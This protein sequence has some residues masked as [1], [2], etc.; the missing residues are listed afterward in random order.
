MGGLR[1]L[2]GQLRAGRL[3]GSGIRR[4]RAGALVGPAPAPH[5]RD[6]P[7]PASA[8]QAAEVTSILNGSVLA[9]RRGSARPV[10]WPGT[11][12]AAARQP[13]QLADRKRAS[14]A[15]VGAVA[16]P[17][18]VTDSAAAAFAVRAAVI[19]SAPSASAAMNVPV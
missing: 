18:L 3:R 9:G 2:A 11:Q 5:R 1:Q 10:A 16:G 12:G 13:G 14:S 4:R 17:R 6:C 7:D 19:S 15:A 8:G